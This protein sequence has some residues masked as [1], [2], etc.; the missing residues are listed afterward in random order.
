VAQK[1]GIRLR[2]QSSLGVALKKGDLHLYEYPDFGKGVGHYVIDSYGQVTVS[3]PPSELELR[4][5][6]V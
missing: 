3:E 5:F 4:V 1:H 2:E 6:I